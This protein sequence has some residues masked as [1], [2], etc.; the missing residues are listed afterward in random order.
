[1]SNRVFES[2]AEV[3]QF[4]KDKISN[5][6]DGPLSSKMRKTLSESIQRNVNGPKSRGE[7]G[8]SDPF[9]FE[10]LLTSNEFYLEMFPGAAGQT[11]R[12]KTNRRGEVMHTP[13]GGYRTE[14]AEMIEYG[15]WLDLGTLIRTNFKTKLKRPKRPF[16]EKAQEEID[17]SVTTDLRNLLSKL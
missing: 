5:Y 3:Q 17:K 1:M 8:I 12:F 4:I 9:T 2:E 7:G 16:I 10:V 14:F 13:T 11:H 6:A 15:T